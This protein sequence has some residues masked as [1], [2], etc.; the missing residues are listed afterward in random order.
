MLKGNKPS[1]VQILNCLP[2]LQRES[3]TLQHAV[4]FF[5]RYSSWIVARWTQN[6]VAVFFECCEKIRNNDDV[7]KGAEQRRNVKM[8]TGEN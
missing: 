8:T 4:S 1:I 5:Y 7:G 6:R 3:I 2:V